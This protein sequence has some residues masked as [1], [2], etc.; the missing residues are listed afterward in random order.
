MY[1]GHDI[2]TKPLTFDKPVKNIYHEMLRSF[3]AVKLRIGKCEAMKHTAIPPDTESISKFWFDI[4][5]YL[6]DALDVQQNAAMESPSVEAEIIFIKGA[7]YHCRRAN[8][9]INLV[10]F[11]N[12]SL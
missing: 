11:L 2:L 12:K 5:E 7:Y 8:H 3:V 4:I 10:H 6:S 1:L 9:C